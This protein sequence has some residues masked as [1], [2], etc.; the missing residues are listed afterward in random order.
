MRRFQDTVAAAVGPVLWCE[1]DRKLAHGITA[2]DAADLRHGFGFGAGNPNSLYRRELWQKHPF[3]ETLPT[4]EDLEWYTWA[5]RNGLIV[6]AVHEA[7]VRY[8]S[9]RSWRVLY[10][11]GRLD[12]RIGC[13]FLDVEQPSLGILVTHTAKLVLYWC[14]RRIDIHGLKGSFFHYLGVWVEA[15][16]PQP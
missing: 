11:R 2:Y 5:V 13:R 12:H 1:L 15:K 6:A 7:E 8:G 4:A 3:D 14:M 10:R 9:R 16:S